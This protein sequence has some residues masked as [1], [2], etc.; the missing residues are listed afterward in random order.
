MGEKEDKKATWES[1]VWK[2]HKYN[3]RIQL[4]AG[5]YLR[6][7]CPHCEEELT[8]ENELCLEVINADGKTGII[9]LSP[10]LDA[11]EHKTDIKLPEGSE[12]KDLRCPRCHHSFKD[13]ERRCPVDD[14]HADWLLVGICHT[15]V[16]FYF[17]MR[18]GCHWHEI[19]PD[20]ESQIILDDSHEW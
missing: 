9:K 4:K 12:V 15:R 19:T 6:T 8:R 17:C 1:I 20:D 3:E 7:F 13:E 2:P 16:P 5:T 11:Y 10:Y 18:V 14:A